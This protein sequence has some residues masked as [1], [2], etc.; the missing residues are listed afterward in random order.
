MIAVSEPVSERSSAEERCNVCLHSPKGSLA[1]L[2][3]VHTRTL[4][5]LSWPAEEPVQCSRLG[6]EGRQPRWV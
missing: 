5:A 6:E 1:P 2:L 4:S 3:P